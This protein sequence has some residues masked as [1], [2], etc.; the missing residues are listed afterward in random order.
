MSRQI[1]LGNIKILNLNCFEIAFEKYSK[2]L[3]A[4]GIENIPVFNRVE[5]PTHEVGRIQRGAYTVARLV[6]R[7]ETEEKTPLIDEKGC[8]QNGFASLEGDEDYLKKSAKIINPIEHDRL[9]AYY[10]AEASKATLE[11]LGFTCQDYEVDE[12]AEIEYI[13]TREVEECLVGSF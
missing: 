11:K 5:N 1:S 12:N 7:P 13:G 6:F 9:D 4:K 2:E 3:E 10:T 8:I